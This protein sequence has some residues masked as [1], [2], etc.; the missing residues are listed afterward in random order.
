MEMLHN[1][2][3]EAEEKIEEVTELLY[4][5]KEQE[6][7]IK[8]HDLLGLFM[9]LT[10]WVVAAIQKGENVP[11][12]EERFKRSLIEAMEAMEQKDMI[13]FADILQYDIKEQLQEWNIQRE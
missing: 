10:D 13:L 5:K 2:I 3:K 6:V 7:Y 4:Q 12:E 8:I 11:Y 1:K 9:E